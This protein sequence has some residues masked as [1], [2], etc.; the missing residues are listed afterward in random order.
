MHLIQPKNLSFSNITSLPF[1]F[2]NKGSCCYTIQDNKFPV[3][4][5]VCTD[6]DVLY[7]TRRHISLMHVLRFYLFLY[8]VRK[9]LLCLLTQRD[10]S[11]PL[12]VF[13]HLINPT[14]KVNERPGR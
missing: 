5:C 1:H 8:F 2:L 13:H 11:A 3:M 12:N 7:S 9:H 6:E 14:Q 4:K 10:T